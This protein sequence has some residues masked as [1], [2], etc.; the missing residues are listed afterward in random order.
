MP[1]YPELKNKSVI[2]TGAASPGGIGETIA[3]E[4][5]H[6]G[7][8][9]VIVDIDVV[10][11]ARLA[12]RISDAGGIAVALQADV[13]NGESVDAMVAEVLRR[14]GRVDVLVNNAGGFAVMKYIG[15][16]DTDEWDA[17]LNLNLKSL[18]LCSRAVSGNM[19]ANGSGRI[20]N[21]SSMAG[22]TPTLPDPV[23]YSAA[24]GGVIS[25]TRA[26]A[27]EMGSHGVLVN[28]IAP[29]WTA[30]TRFLR[31][32]G[33]DAETV[34]KP[35]MPLGRLGQPGD[36]AGAALFLCSDGAAYITGVTLDVNGGIAML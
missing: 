25:F 3:L 33:A 18:F 6:E 35:R 2:V 24:K 5:A 22:R 20:V 23:H 9:V 29:G 31:I 26:L 27:Q 4:F 11:A 13:T 28:T 19:R 21:I 30:T 1:S 36:I 7:S 16:I 14:H 17:V 34:L 12:A 10:G 8:Q 32:R 15:E